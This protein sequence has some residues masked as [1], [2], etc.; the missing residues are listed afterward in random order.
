VKLA[1]TNKITNVILNR[2]YYFYHNHKC[3]IVAHNNNNEMCATIFLLVVIFSQCLL[4][5]YVQIRL[6]VA[7][8]WFFFK[9]RQMLILPN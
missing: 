3:K 8:E 1:N 4:K 9:Q 6:F 5:D 2:D 7:F